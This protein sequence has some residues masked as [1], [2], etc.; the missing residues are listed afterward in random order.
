MIKRVVVLFLF[1]FLFSGLL[2]AQRS[3]FHGADSKP[4]T[5]DSTTSLYDSKAKTPSVKKL[6][7]D[8]FMFQLGYNNWIRPDSI[9][10]KPFGFVFNTFMC[11]DFPIKKSKMSFAT[12]LGI[13]TSVVYFNNQKLANADTGTYGQQAHILADTSNYKRYKLNT[14]YLQAPFELR[15]YSNTQNRNR[16]FKAAL[17]VQVGL[18]LGAHTKEVTSVGGT[19]IK[20]KEDTKRY[21]AP[22]NFAGTGRIGLGNFSLFAS[23]NITGVFKTAS[24]PAVT[25]F[26]VGIC[27]SGL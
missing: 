18:F 6:A 2:W 24:G 13:N 3:G 17:G 8:H 19:N 5:N 27:L 11:F 9:K 22:W 23:Y 26:S 12:G 25:P 20:Y 1:L 10:I 15:Y 16:G 21:M 14:T 7:R 4:Y